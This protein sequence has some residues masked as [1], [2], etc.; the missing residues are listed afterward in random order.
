MAPTDS[1]KRKAA[2]LVKAQK[3]IARLGQ[4]GVSTNPLYNTN[5][6]DPNSHLPYAPTA[7]EIKANPALADV[8]PRAN[9]I[10]PKSPTAAAQARANLAGDVRN[11]SRQYVE[12]NALALTNEQSL[13][14]KGKTMMGRIFDYKDEADA[15]IMGLSMAPVESVFDGF[16][17]HFVGGYDLLSVGLGGIISAMPGG[18]RTLSYDELSGGKGVGEV[19]SGE[20]EPGSAPSPGQIA[21]ASVAAESKRIREGGARLTDVLLLNPATAPFILAGIKA[22][23]SPLQNDNF[24]IANKEQRDKAFASGWEQWM[25]GT[26]DFGLAFADPLIGF[27]VAAKLVRKG[28]LGAMTTQANA[29]LAKPVIDDAMNLITNE[30]G[31]LR[32][33]DE[34]ID[35]VAA[36]T[37]RSAVRPEVPGTTLEPVKPESLQRFLGE[38]QLTPY[39]P[40]VTKDTPMPKTDNPT[41]PI[42]Y[43]IAQVDETGKK[44]MSQREIENIVEITGVTNKARVVD[45]LYAAKSV[46]EV[47]LVFQSMMGVAEALPRLQRIAPALARDAFGAKQDQIQALIQMTEHVKIQEAKAGYSAQA[48]VFRTQ[49]KNAEEIADRIAPGGNITDLSKGLQE[50]WANTQSRLSVLRRSLEEVEELRRIASGEK[51]LDPLDPTSVFFNIEEAKRIVDDLES[52]SNTA[53]DLLRR[54]VQDE[55]TLTQKTL[56]LKSNAYARAVASSRLR[57][58]RAAYEFAEEGTSIFP[59]TK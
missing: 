56:P 15:S 32:S 24:D 4:M 49:I 30:A 14:D 58:G 54:T 5:S 25:S 39:G 9:Y 35:D 1:E 34:I 8:L 45:M 37:G 28:L 13:L 53:N 21:I 44:V 57:R 11:N 31:D 55:L 43:K 38:P 29:R 36:N 40:V 16:M 12:D 52:A 50:T 17:R 6:A 23:T 18:V 22:D 3:D 26:T 59:K 47:G 10:D 33:V 7:T 2:D 48:E 20:M 41:V 51:I 19:L 27:G 46:L 42:I